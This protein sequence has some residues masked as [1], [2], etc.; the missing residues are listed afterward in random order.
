MSHKDHINEVEIFYSEDESEVDNVKI[1]YSEDERELGAADDEDDEESS[2]SEEEDQTP[3]NL[4]PDGQEGHGHQ[5]SEHL[6]RKVSSGISEEQV[7][8]RGLVQLN[9]TYHQKD[10][11]STKNQKSTIQP[12]WRA[13]RS[14]LPWLR[15]VR[16]TLP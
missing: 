3:Q 8:E 5:H 7:T 11:R 4:S 1:F 9:L 13:N 14:G 6:N 16:M 12:Q 10:S 2:N 15:L